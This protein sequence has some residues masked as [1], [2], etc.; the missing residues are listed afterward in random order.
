MPKTRKVLRK[1]RK[2]LRPQEKSSSEGARLYSL[3][4][5]LDHVGIQTAVSGPDPVKLTDGSV[6]HPLLSQKQSSVKNEHGLFFLENIERKPFSD[7]GPLVPT[8][9]SPSVLPWFNTDVY[10]VPRYLITTNQNLKFPG[11]SK[12]PFKICKKAHYDFFAGATY[13]SF[14]LQGSVDLKKITGIVLPH[15]VELL[16]LPTEAVFRAYFGSQEIKDKFVFT[17]RVYF[18]SEASVSQSEWGEL[19]E[20]FAK[21][22]VSAFYRGPKYAQSEVTRLRPDAFICHDSR[23]KTRVARPIA[24]KLSSTGCP[25]WYDEFSLKVGDRLRESVERG[26]KDCRKCIL[27]VS[28]FFLRNKG[29]TTE[30][31]NSIFTKELF[32]KSDVILPVWRGVTPADVYAYSP[33]L[34]NR[35]ALDWDKLGVDKVVTRLRRAIGSPSIECATM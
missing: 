22:G 17:K 7:F 32:E 21:I 1:M 24:M 12:A 2:A 29:W 23:D 5:G 27:I 10:T 34:A 33:A 18:Y 15:L 20:R 31:F 8:K 14:Y 30:E 28:P 13:L 25:V 9:A 35:F 11:S 16:Q 19:K 26:L 4:Y 3:S 6:A